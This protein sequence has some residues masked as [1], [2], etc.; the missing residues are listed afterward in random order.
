MATADNPETLSLMPRAAQEDLIARGYNR[1]DLGRIAAIFGVGAVAARAGQPA[2]AAPG[3]VPAGMVRIDSN[4]CWTGPFPAGQQAAHAI[5]ATSNRYEPADEHDDLIRTISAIEGVPFDWIA[6]WP[7]SSDPLCRAVVTFCSPG[8]GLVTGNPTFELAWRTAEWLGAS[9]ARVPLTADHRHDVKAMLAANPNAGVYYICTPNNPTGTV[10]PLE[11]VAWLVKNKPAGA[12]VL[13]DEA[14]IHWAG[15]PSAVALMKDSPD[16]LVL[17]TFSKMF[18]MAGMRMGFIM[19]RPG[20]LAKMMRYDGGTQSGSLPLPSL[21]CARASLGEKAAIAQRR[22]EMEAARDYA[23]LAVRAEGL[24]L[25]E[26]SR[27]NMFMI[28]WGNRKGTAMQAAFRAQGVEIGRSWDI[29][30][31]MSRITVGSLAEMRR[32]AA[33]LHTVQRA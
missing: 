15:S 23:Q 6:P 32:F 4:E 11:D 2:W 29:W 10:T 30:P 13:V 21:A 33:A 22:A 26:G 12:K 7:G 17:R 1:R 20:D 18:G 16:V 31:N 3:A 25:I 9:L 19:G 28:D 8:R 24:R 5:V 27:A 14:Y